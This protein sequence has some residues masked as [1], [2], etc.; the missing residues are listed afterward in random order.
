MPILSVDHKS[1]LEGQYF[2][3][4]RRFIPGLEV[5]G[6]MKFHAYNSRTGEC[7]KVVVWGSPN[8]GSSGDAHGR[9]DNAPVAA[10]PGQWKKGDKLVIAPND[11]K[12]GK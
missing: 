12:S 1:G 5:K 4:M 8:G 2:N 9:F 11:C 3:F 7:G 6:E 10:K